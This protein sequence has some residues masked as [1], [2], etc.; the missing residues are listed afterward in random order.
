MFAV[1]LTAHVD[2]VLHAFEQAGV[3]DP[4][5]AIEQITSLLDDRASGT[6]AFRG[7]KLRSEVVELLDSAPMSDRATQER[8]YEYLLGKLGAPGTSTAAPTPRHIVSLMVEMTAPTPT[9]TIIDP[10][11]GTAGFLVAAGDYL[12]DHHPRIWLDTG[13]RDHFNNTA[14]TG[15]DTDAA[16]CSIA[17]MNL[18]LH[19]VQNPEILHRDSLGEEGGAGRYSLVVANPPIGGT[20]DLAPAAKQLLSVV[21][22]RKTDLLFVA[23]SLRLLSDGGRAAIIV[24]DAVLFGTT[25]AHKDLRRTLVDEHSLEAVVRLPAGVLRPGSHQSAATQSVS[26]LLVR[27]GAVTRNVWFYD[28]RADGFTADEKRLP[29]ESSDLP[30]LLARWQALSSRAAASAT[31]TA[32]A[33]GSV[34]AV[35][36]LAV[37]VPFVS[38]AERA[39]TAQSFLVPREEIAEHDYDLTFNRYRVVPAEHV[40]HRSP[41]DILIDIARLELQ[42]QQASAALARSLS[43]QP[44][45]M[46]QPGT[47][48]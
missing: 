28:V 5:E 16:L 2:E 37:S 35:S 26:I 44:E 46:A 24:P 10:T 20:R 7:A 40:V 23:H 6:S 25:K 34:P 27:Q 33:P 11:V 36:V 19:G 9:D 45:L 47:W 39:R 18:R 13:L 22:T 38:E 4:L 32:Q 48:R 15:V 31:G 29:C 17:R 14:F 12:R 21:K 3:V 1:E 43:G 41:N 8:V 42:I 30:D